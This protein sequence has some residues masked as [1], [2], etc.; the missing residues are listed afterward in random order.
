MKKS[1][2]SI[3]P[4]IFILSVLVSIYNLIANS[5]IVFVWVILFLLIVVIILCIIYWKDLKDKI[6]EIS[7]DRYI[8][9]IGVGFALIAYN[10]TSK[11]IE[12]SNV[13][14]EKNSRDS[15]SLFKVQLQQAYDLNKS[16]IENNKKL[17]DSLINELEEIQNINTIQGTATNNLLKATQKQ[18]ELTDQSLQ[19]YI[20]ETRPKFKL[21]ANKVEIIDSVT[22]SLV[23]ISIIR[24]I[25]N[26]G[27]RD[28][29]ESEFRH[30]FIDKNN[31]P[32]D[33]DINNTQN[34]FQPNQTSIIIYKPLIFTKESEEFFYWFQIR[35]YDERRDEYFDRS[36]YYHY[37]EDVQGK[38]FYTPSIK[39]QK[40]L[41]TIVDAELKTRGLSLTVN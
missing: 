4:H 5:N 23:R 39:N 6:E 14:F 11:Q 8:A 38:V 30:L 28:A 9:L 7:Y 15:D 12:V 16:H 29:T 35:F 27:N 34:I 3:L 33:F 19:D 17:N 13:Q 24:N 36:Y 20:Y 10:Q 41:R 31:K 21:G 32:I 1:F 26:T 18:Y 2:I 22:E 37:H 40:I 25:T